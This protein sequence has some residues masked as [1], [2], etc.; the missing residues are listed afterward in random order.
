MYFGK[1]FPSQI[2]YEGKIRSRKEL[3][4]HQN[5]FKNSHMLFKYEK[6]TYHDYLQTRT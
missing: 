6:L 5:E 1:A 4:W 2:S 3:T